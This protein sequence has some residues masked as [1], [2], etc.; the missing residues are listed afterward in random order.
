MTRKLGSILLALSLA[1]TALLE[2]GTALARPPGRW[3]GGPLDDG[4]LVPLMIRAANLTPAQD[5]KVRQLVK[6]RRASLRSV[7]QHLR[8]AEDQLATKLLGPGNVRSVDVQPELQ[9][10]VQRREQLLLESTQTVLDIRALLT[11]EQLARAAQVN[12]RVR[13]LQTE[14]RQLWQQGD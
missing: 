8:E 3:S 7:I 14:M 11:A 6:A 4:S 13:Q 12:E 1:A 2:S 9:R 5:A 10:I